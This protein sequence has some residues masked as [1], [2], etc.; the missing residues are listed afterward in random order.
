MSRT[1]ILY[2]LV[3]LIITLIILQIILKY[4]IKNTEGFQIQGLQIPPELEQQY[5]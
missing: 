3:L 5:Q 2:F 4:F 1:N